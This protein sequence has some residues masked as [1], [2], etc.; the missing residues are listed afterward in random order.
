[1][2]WISVSCKVSVL[3][4]LSVFSGLVLW[5]RVCCMCLVSLGL[6]RIGSLGKFIVGKVGLV[7]E[8]G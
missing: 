3:M 1:M 8:I 6:V 7:D 5:L 2:F 4:W